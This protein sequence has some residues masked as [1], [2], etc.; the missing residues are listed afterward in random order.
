MSGRKESHPTFCVEPLPEY[1]TM[2]KYC[3]GFAI[4]GVGEFAVES[5]LNPAGAG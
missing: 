3:D 2:S 1:V 4:A 5:A